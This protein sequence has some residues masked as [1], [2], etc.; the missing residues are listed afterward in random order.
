MEGIE[1][2]KIQSASAMYRAISDGPGS[3]GTKLSNKGRMETKGEFR[4]GLSIY[5]MTAETLRPGTGCKWDPKNCGGV[6]LDYNPQNRSVYVDGSDAHTLLV[7]STGSKKS[8]LVVIPTVRILA[9]AGESMVIS[10]PKGEIYQRTAGYLQEKGYT[11]NAINLRDPALGDSWNLLAVPY[12]MFAAGEVD[13]ACGFINDAA[14]NL[15]EISGKDPYWDYSSRDLLFGLILLLFELCKELGLSENTVNMQN[16]LRLKEELFSSVTS[17]IIQDSVLWKYAK[18]H[19]LV[20]TKLLGTVICPSDTL[21]C[22]LSV[23]DQHMSCFTLMPQLIQMLSTSTID[24]RDAGFQKQAVFL[25]M[26]DEKTTYHKLVAIF[27]KQSYEFLIDVAYKECENNRFPVRVNFLLDE[28][29]SL[30]AISDFPQMITASRSRNIRFTLIVQSKHQ[31]IQRYGEETETIQSNCGNWLFLTSREIALLREISEL[32]GETGGK[33]PLISVSRLQHLDKEAGECL[34]FSGRLHPYL[35]NLA[36]IDLY[37]KKEYK[38]L[39]MKARGENR[40]FQTPSFTDLLAAR[41]KEQR[42]KEDTPKNKRAA[43]VDGALDKLEELDLDINDG[44][45]QPNQLVDI[46]EDWDDDLDVDLDLD[47]DDYLDED[48]DMDLDVDQDEG[49]D[50]NREHENGWDEETRRKLIARFEELFGSDDSDGES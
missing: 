7:G 47:L 10:D 17:S 40:N 1:H 46:D 16:V 13:K 20:K 25:I 29:S 39:P 35:A 45:N 21:S 33:G 23:F 15:I 38:T 37:D 43:P 6:P 30:P 5:Q 28:F 42:K 22:I 8:R 27:I 18:K 36:D 34:V 26:P 19:P 3:S 14:V 32:S 24:L 4:K 2:Q 9:A 44:Q 11:V 49:S 48:L 50:E 31:L 12:Q 41:E